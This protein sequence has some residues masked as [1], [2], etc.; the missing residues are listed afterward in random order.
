MLLDKSARG[1][2]KKDGFRGPQQREV[3]DVLHTIK[4]GDLYTESG[5]TLQGSF[6]ALSSPNFATKY[7]LKTSR[8]DPYN[9]LLCTALHS[10]T[11]YQNVAEIL[12]FLFSPEISNLI[13]FATCYRNVAKFGRDVA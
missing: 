2:R 13:K 4:L 11:F 5:Q 9:T 8:R 6:S 12:R 1:E 3:G 10:Q 7:S